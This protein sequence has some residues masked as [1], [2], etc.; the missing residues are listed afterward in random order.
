[1]KKSISYSE[2]GIAAGAALVV[3]PIPDWLIVT[4]LSGVGDGVLSIAA[5]DNKSL[6]SRSCNVVLRSVVG[7]LVAT[8]AVTQVAGSPYLWVD[9]EGKSE[10][11]LSFEA[12][13]GTS[14]VDII[15]NGGWGV[16][17]IKTPTFDVD[18]AGSGSIPFTG[19]AISLTAKKIEL[20]SENLQ[21]TVQCN[22]GTV[23]PE[24]FTASTAASQSQTLSVTPAQSGPCEVTLLCG[25][26]V[27]GECSFDV[28]GE[29][30]L[31][32]FEL[33]PLSG[34]LSHV[35]ELYSYDLKLKKACP[36]VFR[37][38]EFQL[39]VKDYYGCILDKGTFNVNYNLATSSG[40]RRFTVGSAGVGDTLFSID[41]VSFADSCEV[42]VYLSA[43]GYLA[44]V[45]SVSS[46]LEPLSNKGISYKTS[47]TDYSVEDWPQVDL[48]S[49]VSLDVSY[50]TAGGC[51]PAVAFWYFF[52][53]SRIRSAS[54]FNGVFDFSLYPTVAVIRN[55]FNSFLVY[56]ASSEG[57]FCMSNSY[58]SGYHFYF[59]SLFA[60]Y[61]RP[62]FSPAF[63]RFADS[64]MDL[65]KNSIAASPV[66]NPN[67]F[68]DDRIDL[69]RAVL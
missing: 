14:G 54:R 46:L 27:V 49:A 17:N 55:L 44:S 56:S 36:D 48:E 8:V 35:G 39:R 63:F 41:L 3:D 2:L 25:R 52:G 21:V 45:Y 60:D 4:P 64:D 6:E 31:P 38:L 65:I 16:V 22:N 9:T 10:H 62:I 51:Y 7:D 20:P 43:V 53:V 32:L 13:G 50:K 19:K 34:E 40:L 57:D 12:A 28:Y 37:S 42:D 59:F 15:S 18:L 67:V 68:S 47:I 1:M 24:V 30:D 66:S 29:D 23:S 5:E 26:Q 61:G 11:D 33:V 69:T 58:D